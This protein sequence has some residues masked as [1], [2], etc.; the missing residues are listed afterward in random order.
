[1]PWMD[2]KYMLNAHSHFAFGGWVTLVLMVLMVYDVL[3][4][5]AREKKIYQWL[6]AGI[7]LNAWGMLL[8]FPFEGYA[9][10]SILFSTI[11][12]FVTY[13][14]SAVYIFDILKAPVGRVARL[15]AISAVV[16]LVVSSVGPF[17]LAYLLATKSGNFL[18]YKDAVYTYLHFQYNGFFTLSVCS[19]FFHRVTAILPPVTQRNVRTF[20]LLLCLS[21]LPSVFLSYLW[22]YP[23]STYRVI[24]AVGA[25]LV[26]ASSCWFIMLLPSL[27]KFFSGRPLAR[28]IGICSLTAFTLKMLLQGGT[29]FPAIGDAVFG[30]RPVI[31]GF[32]HLVFLAF[33]SLFV[34][35]YLLQTNALPGDSGVAKTA[36]RIFASSV[37]ANELTLMLQGLGIMFRQNSPVYPWLL[38]IIAICLFV[39]ALLL[40]VTIINKKAVPHTGEQQN[41]VEPH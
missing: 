23:E 31:I 40:A 18:L 22:Q 21:I 35:A 7:A 27:I 20:A 3:P 14:F 12:I 13:I 34:I 29:I 5:P 30:N 10:L 19:I 17:T 24:A 25:L 15:L 2:F 1:M 11:F 16:C 33:V 38:W 26:F 8:S 39:S 6:L 28:Y 41:E 4:E 32:L 36:I 9:F 37:I